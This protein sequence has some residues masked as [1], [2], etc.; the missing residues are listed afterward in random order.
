M[1]VARRLRRKHT[2]GLAKI[3]DGGEKRAPAPPTRDVI[4][5]AS[6][7]AVLANE[8]AEDTNVVSED[9]RGAEVDLT[10]KHV[11]GSSQFEVIA[12]LRSRDLDPK[13][14]NAAKRERRAR[15]S[16]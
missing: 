4:P 3:K 9:L 12:A 16:R 11:W 2:Q 1:S 10:P 7:R 15:R 8:L 13:D 14:R 5:F 6:V